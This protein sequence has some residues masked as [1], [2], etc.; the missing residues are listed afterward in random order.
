MP[1][2]FSLPISVTTSS[3]ESSGRFHF[4]YWVVS[5]VTGE[6]VASE[7]GSLSGV[8][9]TAGSRY[10]VSLLEVLLAAG[11]G[12]VCVVGPSFACSWSLES[13]AF[14]ILLAPADPR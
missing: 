8:L 13:I 5:V 9:L 3:D 11:T 4:L 7:I 14:L 1:S 10:E 6:G 2:N 12:E